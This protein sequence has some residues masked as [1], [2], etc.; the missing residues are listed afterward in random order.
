M[1]P[2]VAR[3]AQLRIARATGPEDDAH[4]DEFVG[5]TPGASFAHQAGWRRIMDKVLGRDTMPLVAV[6]PDGEWQGVLPLVRMRAPLLGHSFISLPFLNYGGPIGTPAAQYALLQAA[7]GQAVAARADL[8]QI[9][10]RQ[11]LPVA[12]PA[13]RPKVLVLLDLPQSAEDLWAGFPAKLRSQIRRPQKEGMEFRSGPA[14]LDAFYDVFSRN[15]R[16]LGTPV[17]GRA[18]FRAVAGEFPEFTVGAVYLNGE[19]VAAGAGFT[20]RGEFELTWASSLRQYSRLAPNMLLYWSL[21]EVMIE[22]GVR[23]FN[24]GRSTPGASTHT[25]KLQWGGRSVPLPWLEWTLRPR[26]GDGEPSAMAR[27]L[28]RT[29][30]RLPVRVTNTIGPPLAS[31]LP[32]W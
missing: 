27:L 17:Y 18:F 29:W 20:W 21:M 28:S 31:R 13:A 19:P 6:T 5:R 24:F 7:L 23:V 30:Q 2:L 22:R 11:P 25:F 16:D 3:A 26:K 14:E 9:R 32:W 1:T 8:L 10:S 4:W 12:A 15:M